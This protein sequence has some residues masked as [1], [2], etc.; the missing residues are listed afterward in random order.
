MLRRS[1]SQWEL[2]DNNSANGTYVNG[3]RI[4]RRCWGPAT[5]SASVIS[6]C[7]CPGIGWWNTLT[8]A[9]SPMRP[10]TCGW[11]PT[12]AP[13]NPRCC[14]PMSALPC[15]AQPVGGGGAQRGR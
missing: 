10:P 1:G 8:P 5:L 12:R 2:V 15:P 14:W 7:I 11:S 9:T 4:S 13:K 6:C 3:T